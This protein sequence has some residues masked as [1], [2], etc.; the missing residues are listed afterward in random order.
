MNAYMAKVGEPIKSVTGFN[1]MILSGAAT[2][3]QWRENRP[4]TCFQASCLYS[5]ARWRYPWKFEDQKRSII[6][7]S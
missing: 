1:T 4:L 3:D 7:E 5:Y 6:D 2:P